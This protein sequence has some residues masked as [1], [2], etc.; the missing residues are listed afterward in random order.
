MA[1]RRCSPRRRC[2]ARWTRA[3]TFW[4]FCAELESQGFSAPR[5]HQ[6]DVCRSSAPRARSP[7]VGYTF[8][9]SWAASHREPS[10][11]FIA[12]TRKAKEMLATSDAEWERIAPRIGASDADH[13]RD[14][15]PALSRRH[16]APVRSTT[17][18]PTRARS[19]A[20]WPRSAAATWSGRRAS[21][22]PARSTRRPRRVRCCVFCS[23]A[24]F[25]S[26]PGGSPRSSP[27][28]RSCPSPPAVLAHRRGSP[29]A[30]RCS[31]NLGATLA[32]VAV[33]F[34]LAMALGS[35]IGYLMGG[36]RL[37]DRLGDPWLIV[38][39]NL[40]A[41]VIIVLAYIWA[42]LT[43]TAAIAAVALNKLPI[44]TVT[45][46]E[47]ARS[48][49]RALDEMAQVFRMSRAGRACATSCCRSLRPILRPRPAPACRWSGRSC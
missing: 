20:C 34:V 44:A 28:P 32:R 9:E 2:R 36:S 8:D 29:L 26:R 16:S 4:N 47:G 10:A 5:R 41:L 45:V 3:S 42:G 31:F 40:P 15:P 27:A 39:L 43:E 24:L 7:I 30:A 46:R 12:M 14:L 37:A 1:R 35:G 33:A 11:R 21:S 48:L 6:D 13:A 38:L 17:R 23:F 49:D 18:K 19:I 25:C 22:I